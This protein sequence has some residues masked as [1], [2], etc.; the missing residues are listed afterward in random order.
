MVNKLKIILA[1]VI[2][3]LI[4]IFL[5]KILRP[6]EMEWSVFSKVIIASF[7]V[8]TTGL[9]LSLALSQIISRKIAKVITDHIVSSLKQGLTT[10]IEEDHRLSHFE[11]KAIKGFIVRFLRH[12]LPGILTP[13]LLLFYLLGVISLILE[14]VYLISFLKG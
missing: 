7:V 9:I 2:A 6:P 10:A 8:I 11:M 13:Y 3:I 4:I 14:V 1:I 12:Q 5:P